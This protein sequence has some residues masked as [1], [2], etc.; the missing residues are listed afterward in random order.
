MREKH[1]EPPVVRLARDLARD[2]V[3]ALRDQVTRPWRRGRKGL[4]AEIGRWVGASLSGGAA[5]L[6]FGLAIRAYFRRR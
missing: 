4:A 2:Q 1:G 5:L 6:G 3:V